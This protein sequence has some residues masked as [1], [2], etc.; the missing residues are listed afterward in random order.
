VRARTRERAPPPL[1]LLRARA[2][3]GVFEHASSVR[4]NG[5]I[6]PARV[7]PSCTSLRSTVLSVA[8]A[9]ERSGSG[10]S[11]GAPGGRSQR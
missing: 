9:S 3:V 11:T 5:T 10:T 8:C 2:P 6:T 4:S 1:L 7:M